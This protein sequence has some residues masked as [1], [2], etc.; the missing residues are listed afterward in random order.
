MNIEQIIGDYE[1]F[2]ADIFSQ[3]NKLHINIKGVPVSHICYRV[4]SI[5]EYERVREQLKKLSVEY[6]ET[7]F[8]GRPVSLLVLTNPLFVSGDRKI[9][10]VE[11][12]SPRKAHEYDSGLEHVGIVV[13]EK[14]SEFKEKYK[15]VFTGEK[16]RGWF[17]LPFVTFSNGKTVKFYEKPLKEIVE[18]EGNKFIT[19]S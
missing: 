12:P 8:N 16:D 10:L 15:N 3:L 6:V 1:V 14:L 4:K 18:L 17:S 11:L 2:F 9:S 19:L 5:E 7:Q 13:G